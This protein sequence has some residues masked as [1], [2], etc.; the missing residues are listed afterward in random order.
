MKTYG[1]MDVYLYSSTILAS[2]LDGGQWSA[3]RSGR[4]TFGEKTPAPIA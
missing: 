4:F 2:A 3:S 1:G